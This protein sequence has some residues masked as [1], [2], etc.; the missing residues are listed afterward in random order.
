MGSDHLL[1]RPILLICHGFPPVRG[2][3]G[4]RWA[5]FAKELARRGYP[6]HVIRSVGSK[7]R[8]DSLW[9][10]DAASPG[11]IH[12]PIP[13]NYPVVLHKRPITSFTEK[14]M[15][16]VWSKLL[17][18][19]VKG[20]FHDS[21]VFSRSI[22]LAKAG[23]LI[24]AHGIRN[25]IV[26][27]APFR[28][29]AFATELKKDFPEIN[30]VSDFRD[31]WTWG[32]DYGLG[33]MGPHRLQYEK[34][35][36][37]LVVHESDKIISPH[38]TVIEHLRNTYG[39]EANRYVTIPHAIDPDELVG[40]SPPAP[41]GVFR[42]IYAGSLYGAEEAQQ[43]FGNLLEAFEALR[44]DKPD[45][46]AHCRLDLYITGHDTAAYELL[47]KAR[48]LQDRIHFHAPVPPQEIFKRMS[49]SDLV[50]TFIPTPNKDI[51]GTKF[52]EIFHL[53]IP[54][55][56]IGE[57]GLVGRTITG[58]KLGDSLRVA[59]LATELP[60]IISGE[61]TIEV[62]RNADHSELLLAHIT[63]RLI[64]EVLV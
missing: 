23:S 28:L 24:Q 37:A 41:D 21:T 32:T 17:P 57:P 7:G 34:D 60:R 30:L 19:L 58:R 3:G 15:Y 44:R 5:K 53:R 29:M 61:R 42:L 40:W 18:L 63:D 6:V 50:L 33:T 46:Y 31:V 64:A 36:E 9:S 55:L 2:I 48:D 62:D 56:H 4:R 51:L 47:V 43:Y 49:H 52:S 45:A 59:E 8:L 38:P 1:H 10:A 54:V 25:V 39:G 14:V 16:R 11:I 13:P 27:G 26:S 22:L 12:H 20:N 35:L